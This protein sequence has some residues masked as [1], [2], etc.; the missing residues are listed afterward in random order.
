MGSL[1]RVRIDRSGENAHKLGV[2]EILRSGLESLARLGP[3]DLAADLDERLERYVH[4][5]HSFNAVHR[6][7][8]P[9][10]PEAIASEHI[11]D[12]L[13]LI[14]FA[15]GPLLD[16]GSGA[17][18][19]GLVLKLALPELSVTLVEPR[20]KPASFL[21][22]MRARL[23]LKDLVLVDRRAEEVQI[24]ELAGREPV[25]C[26]TAK[27]FGTIQKL[28]LA[29]RHLLRPDAILL[30]P[31]SSATE[32]GATT[33]PHPLLPHRFIHRMELGSA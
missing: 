24:V 1:R 6:I 33:Q 23:G 11:V 7:V 2:R 15:R 32:T 18:L 28:L 19:P 12:S 26:A 25:A 21:A 29:S 27:G 10:S 31:S 14:P 9:M 4:E 3:F 20:Q 22:L 17:G 5:I 13:G 8:G 16:V 30:V